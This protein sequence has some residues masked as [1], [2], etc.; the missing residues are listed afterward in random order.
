MITEQDLI[1]AIA[2][3]QGER[4]PNANTCI[5]LAAY[6][7]IRDAMYGMPTY[8]RAAA[9]AVNYSG[10]SEFARAI[11]GM[12]PDRAWAVMDEMMDTIRVIMPRLY[13]AVMQ[14]L[15]L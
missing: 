12:E 14:K 15:T 8:S 9:P 1:D 7:T 5:K 13:D 11:N 2:E 10:E 3:C 6:Y 4:H